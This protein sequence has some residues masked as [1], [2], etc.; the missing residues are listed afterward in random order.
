MP[1]LQPTKDFLRYLQQNPAV[2]AQI[3]AAPGRTLLYAGTFFRPVWQEIAAQK[4]SSSQLADKQVLPDVLARIQ[5]PGTAYP[6]LLAWAQDLDRLEPWRENGF[7]AWR[8][9]SGV[10][11]ANA[12]GAVSFCVGSKVNKD[13]KVFA[14]TEVALLARNPN[15]DATTRDLV[16]YFQRCVQ[17]GQPQ[18]NA[19]FI[20]G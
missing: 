3:R 7:I 5:V 8:A 14:A 1:L 12:L 2:R 10:F 20:A 17:S 13:Q 11:A 18:I 19:G 4:R 9:L 6:N 15:V 16:A